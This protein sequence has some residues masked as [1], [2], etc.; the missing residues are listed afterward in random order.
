MAMHRES[1]GQQVGVQMERG[2]RGVRD[3]WLTNFQFVSPVKGGGRKW[4]IKI[5]SRKL[6][7]GDQVRGGGIAD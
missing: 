3:V 5:G 4:E 2:V 1:R 6:H 7:I